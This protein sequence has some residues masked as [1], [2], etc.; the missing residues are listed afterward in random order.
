MIECTDKREVYNINLL[1]A[2]RFVHKA[3]ERVTEKTIR[4]CFLHAGIIQEVILTEIECNVAT[5]EEDEDDLSL[6][7]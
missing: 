2:A 6:S 7:E 4:N 3:R 1:D 5:T